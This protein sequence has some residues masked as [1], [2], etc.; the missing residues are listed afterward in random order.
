MGDPVTESESE[1]R[2]LVVDDNEDSAEML[3]MALTAMGYEARVSL[4]ASSA[5]AMAGDF[6]P[7]VAI[8]D[9]GLPVMDGFE[10]AGRL[11]K[12]PGLSGIRLIALTGYG[13][14]SDRQKTRD[15]GFHHH[16]VKP[17]DLAAIRHAVINQLQ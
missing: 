16:L 5:L 9:L 10:L 17:V 11:R 12:V 7:T 13:Q 6:I 14:D 8:L 2:I 4:D 3:A 1:T 15:A